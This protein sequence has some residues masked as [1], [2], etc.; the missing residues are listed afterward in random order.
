MQPSPR[1]Q[2]PHG[3]TPD[4]IRNN[5]ALKGLDVPRTG[6][7]GQVGTL[8]TK[9]LVIAGEPSVTTAGHARGALL[10]AYDKATGADSGGV[11]MPAPQT[12]SPMS[13]MLGGKQYVVVAIG[14]AGYPGA[15]AKTAAGAEFA[16]ASCQGGGWSQ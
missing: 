9:T 6:Q 8:V 7:A 15:E 3:D 5:P 11:L 2:T 16:G 1:W 10:R 4:N 13:Y 12:G 14:G